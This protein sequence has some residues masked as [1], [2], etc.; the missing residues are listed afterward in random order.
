MA[1]L[2]RHH[3]DTPIKELGEALL[4]DGYVVV[5]RA[6]PELAAQGY[7]DLIDDI[8]AAPNGHLPFLGERT[9]RLGGLLKRST[10]VQQLAI[11]PIVMGLAD[12]VLQPYCARYQLNFSGIMHLLPGAQAQ[13]IHRDGDLYP[14]RHPCPPML[15]PTM[16]ALSDFTSKNGGTIVVPGS[17]TWAE[18]RDPFEDEIASAEMPAGSVLVYLGGTLHGGG[19]NNS[20]GTRT[21]LALQYVVGWLRQEE[22]QYLTNPPEIARTFSQPLQKLIGYD[23]G[24]PYLGMVGGDSPNRVL[25]DGYDGPAQRSDLEVDAFAA[26]QHR[27]SWGS[28]EPSV[29]VPRDGVRVPVSRGPIGVN[30]LKESS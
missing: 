14:F 3:A 26:K 1:E 24:G 17:H 7:R 22:N 11:H 20:E 23:Y 30:E 29:E 28:V 21:G 8:N 18:S 5:E 15:M 2:R 13:Q 6:A 16:W 25:V 27:L 19:T 9:K 4:R 12:H 10:A